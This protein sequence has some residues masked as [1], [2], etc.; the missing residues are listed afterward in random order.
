MNNYVMIDDRK[1]FKADEGDH[2]HFNYRCP[3][4]GFYQTICLKKNKLLY[5]EVRTFRSN[6]IYCMVCSKKFN[7][8]KVLTEEAKKEYYSFHKDYKLKLAVMKVEKFFFKRFKNHDKLYFISPKDQ[9]RLKLDLNCFIPK[10][11]DP[12][13][14]RHLHTRSTKLKRNEQ[15]KWGELI[16]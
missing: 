2:H 9:M 13:L 11:K 3:H 12:E 1:M 16:Y 5:P 14:R 8:D 10:V 6:Q 15:V 7:L 4:C